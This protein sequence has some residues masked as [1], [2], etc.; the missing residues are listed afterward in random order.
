MPYSRYIAYFQLLLYPDAA[1]VLQDFYTFRFQMNLNDVK[2]W[3][4]STNVYA[5][6]D[7]EMNGNRDETTEQRPGALLYLFVYQ[8]LIEYRKRVQ[9]GGVYN[10]ER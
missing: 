3:Q 9:S 4:C 7:T 2:Y 8:L 10:S 1:E 5:K 6:I